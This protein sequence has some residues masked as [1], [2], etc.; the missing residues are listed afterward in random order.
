MLKIEPG[1]QGLR[2]VLREW[3]EIVMTL[4]WEETKRCKDRKD[5]T[6]VSSREAWDGANA[7]LN[8]RGDKTISRASVINFLNDMSDYNVLLYNEESCKGGGRRRYV[9]SSDMAGF[10]RKV[11]EDVLESFQNDYPAEVYEVVKDHYPTVR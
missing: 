7:E 5:W 8:M 1:E 6:G 3:Q 4:V 2:K 10:V 11:I 9:A